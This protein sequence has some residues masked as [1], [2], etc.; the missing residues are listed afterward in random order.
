LSNKKLR[1]NIFIQQIQYYFVRFFLLIAKVLPK[2]LIYLKIKVFSLMGFYC[3]K[4]R[5]ELTVS[6]LQKI[7]N[8]NDKEAFVMAK[9]VYLELS[10]TIA[11][12]LFMF[13]DRFDIDEAIENIN[14]AKEKLTK[15]SSNSS[16]GII[17]I[18]AH[19]SNWELAAQFLAKNGLP[20]L[21]IGRIGS[22]K[23]IERKIT[24]PFRGK[25][26]NRAINKNH[27]MVA[28]AK[29]LKSGGNVGMLIDQKT[30]GTHSAQIPFFGFDAATTLSAASLKL[31][32]NPLVVPI[33]IV[34]K[35]RGK[36]EMYIDEPIDYK[37]GEI[38]DEK[39]KLVA[40]TARYNQ[41]IEHII[42]RDPNQWFWMH[43][44]WKW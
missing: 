27:S 5:R 41:A 33:S 39:E 12:I 26:G 11:E 4:S 1:R 23:I 37:A 32:F 25:Y 38:K 18:T 29:T 34:R 35:S 36:Y 21:A 43:N 24:T 10:E 16:S 9:K 14:E 40:M 44:R 28:M 7:Y 19:Y 8:L 15:I 6:N 31:K 22:N 13:V 3:L 42:S 30:S 2:S 20:M 17:V